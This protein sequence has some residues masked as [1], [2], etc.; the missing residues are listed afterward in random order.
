MLIT[1]TAITRGGQL[2]GADRQRGLQGSVSFSFLAAPAA[3]QNC[4]GLHMRR[5]AKSEPETELVGL[6]ARRW[7]RSRAALKLL[8]VLEQ[9]TLQ[10][11]SFL[12]PLDGAPHR[13]EPWLLQ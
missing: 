10:T 1:S 6:S 9:E 4:D 7:Q 12:L 13:N 11:G 8:S 2:N 5:L 3:F